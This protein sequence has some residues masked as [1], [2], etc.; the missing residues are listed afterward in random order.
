MGVEEL[1]EV[2]EGILGIDARS[3]ALGRGQ[4]ERDGSMFPLLVFMS[5]F[6]FSPAVLIRSRHRLICLH[7]LF[8]FFSHS[9]NFLSILLDP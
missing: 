8:I 7:L 2:P 5:H 3:A 9:T 1:E 4:V 6:L